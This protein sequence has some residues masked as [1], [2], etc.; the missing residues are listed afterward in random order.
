MK[1]LYLTTALGVSVLLAACGGKAESNENAGD[2]KTPEASGTMENMV[3]PTDSQ[4]K[5]AKATGKVTAIDTATGSITL[6][7]SAIPEVNWPA[8]TMEFT[9]EPKLLTGILRRR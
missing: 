2:A 6:D 8:M 5:V 3:M 7:H 4:V 9:A 1:S